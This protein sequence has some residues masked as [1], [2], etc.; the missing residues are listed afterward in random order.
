VAVVGSIYR[1]MTSCPMTWRMVWPGTGF[2]SVVFTPL[3]F[4]GTNILT[5]RMAGATEVYGTFAALIV[6]A[7]WISIHCLVALLGAEINAAVQRRR[8]RERPTPPLVPALVRPPAPGGPPRDRPAP[9]LARALVSRETWGAT[10][11]SRICSCTE[12]CNRA[13]CAG[14]S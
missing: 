6:L 4:A 12:R 14:R 13:T 2:T 3:Q 9:P 8:H 5:R 7:F 1:F 10:T 11:R